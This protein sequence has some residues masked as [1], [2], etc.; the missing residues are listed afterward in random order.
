MTKLSPEQLATAR[1]M[2]DDRRSWHAIDKVL[3]TARGTARATLVPLGY[4]T[5]LHA[6]NNVSERI[7]E[8]AWDLYFSKN[9]PSLTEIADACGVD[10]RAVKRWIIAKGGKIRHAG[11]GRPLGERQDESDPGKTGW[12]KAKTMKCS[13]GRKGRNTYLNSG[14]WYCAGYCDWSPGMCEE[15]ATAENLAAFAR[16][17]AERERVAKIDAERKQERAAIASAQIRCYATTREDG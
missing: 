4:P 10:R 14:S 7:K 6:G 5:T 12:C 11:G 2:R 8:H 3:G 1:M 9:P 17:T 15:E 13:I 16:I